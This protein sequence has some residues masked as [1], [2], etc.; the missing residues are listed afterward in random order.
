MREKRD[1]F[2]RGEDIKIN[3]ERTKLY[4]DYYRAHPNEFPLLKRSG[5]VKHWAENCRANVFDDD[6]F[7]GTPG[8]DERSL[9]V[10]VDGDPGWIL[11]VIDEATFKKAW[12]ADNAA[13]KMADEQREILAEAYD[14]W[15]DISIG[16]MFEG[17]VTDDFYPAFGSGPC[18]SYFPDRE[19]NTRISAGI[20]GHYVAN[21]NKAVNVGFGEVRRQAKAKIDECSGKIFGDR[22]KKHVFYHS[23]VR[24]CDAAVTLARRYAE[25]CRAKA[26]AAAGPERRAE[27]LAMADSLMWIMENPARTYRE[28][29]QA[30]VLYQLLL[31]ADCQ[32]HGQ[33]MGRVDKYVGHLLERD[34]AEGTLTEAQAQELTDAFLLRVCDI[35]VVHGIMLNNEKVIELNE[36]GMNAYMA[37]YTGMTA[38]GGIVLTLGGSNPDG[39]DD[40][41]AMT[42]MMLQSY[43]RMK[44]PDPTVALRIHKNTP[45]DV[46]RLAIESSKICGGMPQLVND[47]VIIPSMMSWGFSH[48]DAADY[49][50]VGCVE[51]GGTGNEWSASGNDGANSVWDMMEVIQLLI[52]GGVSPRTGKTSV[53]VPMLYEY[54]SF[55]EV[56][57][58]FAKIME[59]CLDWTVSYASMYELAYSTFFPCIVA[60]T[61]LDGCMESGKDATEGGAKYNRT[62]LTA[63][64]TSNTGD[65]LMAI[66]KL[67]FDDKTVSLRTLYDALK[68][69][70]DGYENLRQTI[71]NEVP[72]YGND[73]DEVD[74]LASWAL[75]QFADMIGSKYGPRGRY[76]GGTFTMTAHIYFGMALDATPDGRKKGEPIA[77][78]ISPRQGF[79][80]NG[81][82]AYLK[83]A[84]KLP[85]GSLSNGDQLN[86]RF[87]PTAVRGDAGADK[88]R[89]LIAT[90][91]ALGG[92]QVQFNVVGTDKLREAQRKPL[93]NKDLI[94]R[95]AGFSTYFVTLAPDIQDDFITRT[96]QS[97]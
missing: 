11:G 84:A 3:T 96:E 59:Y 2:T 89:E 46:W 35:M 21:F 12:Q 1:A 69:D 43:G 19:G 97:I 95:I 57:E 67:C 63:C 4:T 22:A 9:G 29:L 26:S 76:C 77:D 49:S 10:Y 15:K 92:M 88:L 40:C 14:V 91:F 85:H 64:G 45:G 54:G 80:K 33:S 50:I 90:Y 51:P 56:K 8:P 5:A 13:I 6:I 74:G 65:S 34:L 23:V 93:E 53:R 73:D 25:N 81:P 16:R 7:V 60:S 61:M 52:N 78:A 66:K 36:S 38:T 75:G 39:T 68:A 55:D 37:I 17:A 71:I 47:E 86:I 31:V 87:S 20:Q 30:I 79:D 83:S 58:A 70:W 27:L 94:V 42:R 24:V 62:G 72:H 44:V 18:M 82:T 32:Q 28:G 41:N 48:A